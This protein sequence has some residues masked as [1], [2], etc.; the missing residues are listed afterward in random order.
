M[1]LSL[2]HQDPPD[3]EIR[4]YFHCRIK[5]WTEN[6]RVTNVSVRPTDPVST[7]SIGAVT[8]VGLNEE[9]VS[10]WIAE[11]GVGATTP[12]T[13][14]RIGNGQSNL[15]YSVTDAGGGRW[16][17]RR[18]PLGTLLA[19]AHDVVREHRILSSLQGTKVPVP[20]ILGITEDPEITDAPLVL[21]SYI[22]GIV[23]DGV[24]VAQKLTEDERRAVGLAMPKTLASIHG[25]DL[26]ETGLEDLAS[27]K[28]FAERQ[29]KR[30]SAQ[31]E[32]SKTRDVPDVDR[33]AEILHRNIPEQN[34]VTLVHG[35]FHL[36]N[37][38]TDPVEGRIVAVV[39]WELCTLGEPLADLGALLAYWPEAG[40]KVAGP[41]MASTLE[42]FPNREELVAAYVEATGRDVSA[43]GYWHVLALWKLSIIA[44]GVLR[45]ILD[46]PRNKA[47]HGGPTVALID[48]IVAR[49]VLT[50]DQ[51]GLS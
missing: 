25:V 42:G 35:D 14:E 34:E 41:F 8:A 26:E 21:M 29:L 23:I 44:E 51:L 38:I 6:W 40:D 7:A 13:F 46:D 32:K 36:N 16:V 4:K 50:A 27:R 48:G 9:A 31:W 24:A 39:D 10:A 12:L 22:D 3:W 33:L 43:V 47:E 5:T 20:K 18:P 30:W 45:R 28:P 19:S 49:A 15:T 17:L 11:L 1:Q 37:V 2:Y